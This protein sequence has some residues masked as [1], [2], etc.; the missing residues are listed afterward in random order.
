[1]WMQVAKLAPS[2]A[3]HDEFGMSVAISGDTII[4]GAPNTG[5]PF[6][7]L[8][9]F[10]EPPGGWMDMIE[11]AQLSDHRA[12]GLGSHLAISSDGNKVVGG[13]RADAFVFVKPPSGW[14]NAT[15]AVA[16]MFPPPG[17]EF[18]ANWLAMSGEI[19][20]VGADIG[21]GTTAGAAYVYQL[22]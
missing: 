18:F 22:S 16:A 17:T 6:G 11:S 5:S 14:A 9:V 4:V 20:V 2:D 10:V 19:V 7:A 8:Y 13:A 1:S 3:G 21:G 12:S 15:R